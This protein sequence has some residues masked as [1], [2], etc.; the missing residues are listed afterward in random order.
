M[1]TSVYS[2][3]DGFTF[4]FYDARF[5][6]ETDFSFDKLAALRPDADG[7][8]SVRAAHGRARRTSRHLQ[9]LFAAFLG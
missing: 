3:A 2:L 1:P 9:P 8:S 5:F 4:G 7:T 6:N